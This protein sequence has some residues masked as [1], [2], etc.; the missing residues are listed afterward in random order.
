MS[1]RICGMQIYDER[2][3]MEYLVTA[4]EMRA[5]DTYT[6]EQVG[7]PA[8]VLMER[9][10]LAVT[11]RVLAALTDRPGRVLCVCGTGN[12]GGDGFCVAR[13]L[14]DKGI[15]VD[16]VLVGDSSRITKETATQ[17]AVLKHYGITPQLFLGAAKPKVQGK[18]PAAMSPDRVFAGEYAVI[19]DALFG[20]GLSREVTGSYKE[21]IAAINAMNGVKIAVDIPSGIDA[22]TGAVWGEAVRA[23]ETVALAFYK[24]GHF[25]YPGASYAGKVV[26]ADIGIT[27][28]SFRDK[29]PSMYTLNEPP[30][31]YMPKRR[32]DGNKGTFGKLLIV[33][34]SAGMAGAALLAGESGYRMGA[35]MVKL[36]IPKAI[37]EIVQE[38]LPEA[39]IQTYSG[40][41]GLDK[42]EE[43]LFIENMNWAKAVVIGPGLSVCESGRS[44]LKLAMNES[45]MPLVIDADGLNMLAED[46]ML[47][48]RLKERGNAILTPHMGELAR[49]LSKTTAAV[50]ANE[51]ASVEE[52]AKATGCIVVG[53]S[54]RTHVCRQGSP[55]FLNTAGNDKMATAGSGDVL[56]GMI[57]AI[58]VQ[59]KEAFA[60][61]EETDKAVY[62][63]M[64][65]QRLYE[66]AMTGVYIHACAGDAAAQKA[67]R[68]GMPASDIIKG[69]SLL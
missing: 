19:V 56:A 34:G 37:R 9:A 51:T 48:E 67:G 65:A 32:S 22:D 52:A 59:T 30:G 11:K 15:P 3:D 55:L 45:N 62:N 24:R 2:N 1:L 26:L 57:G 10:A 27:Q 21:A 61:S 12:N 13:L 8:M 5:Y 38:R 4:A 36:V 39:L 28:R 50:V 69:I 23:D 40:H 64:R 20:T 17:I 29:I 7:I 43:Q 33:A 31:E 42:E 63:E 25:L 14:A 18:C 60:D 53:K 49:L 44:F 46:T 35:G 66:C 54:A 68:A 16:T 47:F 6:I 41:N 58:L